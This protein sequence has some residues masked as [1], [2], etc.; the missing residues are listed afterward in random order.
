[1]PINVV[2]VRYSGG[3]REV[4]NQPSIDVFGRR[5]ALLGLGAIDSREEID[6]VAGMQ[7]AVFGDHRT[8]IAADHLPIGP[9][10]MPYRTYNV[11]D[12]IIVPDYGGG[13]IAQRVRSLSGS[14][15]D[16]GEITYSPE[17][18][19]LILEE[20]ERTLLAIKKMADGTLEGE[21]PVATPVSYIGNVKVY[22][23]AP[24][25]GTGA[26]EVRCVYPPSTGHPE[27]SQEL[28]TVSSG[29][30]TYTLTEFYAEATANWLDGYPEFQLWQLTPGGGGNSQVATVTLGTDIFTKYPGTVSDSS[31]V[32]SA[33]YGI[34]FRR[35]PSAAASSGHVYLVAKFV[36]PAG[37]IDV[38]WLGA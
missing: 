38:E 28:R 13:T 1:V 5:E 20:Q 7:L 34:V 12:T 33:D 18:G 17:L 2:L 24:L 32:F 11:G 23:S 36:G 19:D 26:M 14:E 6:R 9:A 27:W 35:V 29:D 31:V 8:A 22:G 37:V 4:R 21:S 3:W 30:G 25:P 10:D 15:D 16:N